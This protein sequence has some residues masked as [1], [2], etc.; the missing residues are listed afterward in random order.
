M[1]V[2]WAGDEAPMIDDDT[3]LSVG[4]A[5]TAGTGGEAGVNDGVAGV[6]EEVLE[7]P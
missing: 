4:I 6:A 1:G 3:I 5:G 7:V 2:L